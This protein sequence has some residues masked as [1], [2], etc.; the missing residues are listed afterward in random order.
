MSALHLTAKRQ[1][2][3]THVC[4]GIT[5]S[6]ASEYNFFL[7]YHTPHTKILKVCLWCFS[8]I[9]FYGYN[10]LSPINLLH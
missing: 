6:V 1:M 2:G 8:F 10:L 4:T 7:L 9:I 5:E 3:R